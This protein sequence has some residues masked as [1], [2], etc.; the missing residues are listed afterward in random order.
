MTLASRG[1]VEITNLENNIGNLPVKLGTAKLKEY[2][3]NLIHYY[4]LKLLENEIRNLDNKSEKIRNI[5]SQNS[6]YANESFNHFKIIDLVKSNAYAKLSEF[7]PQSR[8]KRGLLNGVGTIFKSITG[9]LDANDGERYDNLIKQLHD[10]QIKITNNMKIQNSLSIKLIDEYKNYIRKINTNEK[11]L[12][13]KINNVINLINK[14][15]LDII[16]LKDTLARFINVYEVILSILQDIENSVSFAKLGIIHP[17]IIKPNDLLNELA[18]LTKTYNPNQ[19]PIEITSDNLDSIMKLLNLECFIYKGKIT[20]II[21]IPI[22]LEESFELFHLYPVPIPTAV[23]GQFAVILPRSKFIAKNR[24]DFSFLNEPCITLRQ[25]QYFCKPEMIESR[26]VHSNPCEIGII[27]KGNT[28][29]CKPVLLHPRSL[30]IERLEN[31]NQ[32]IFVIQHLQNVRFT[33]QEQDEVKVLKGTYLIEIPIGCQVISGTKKVTNR[34]FVKSTS[35]PVLFPR[36]DSHFG[37]N[38]QKT[39][40]EIENIGLEDLSDLKL[41]FEASVPQ[42]N[43]IIDYNPSVLSLVI[44]GLLVLGLLMFVFQRL[45]TKPTRGQQP[46][47][48]ELSDVQLP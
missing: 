20:Y 11:L 39:P 27:D 42:V 28:S 30:L 1:K 35:Q 16:I 13:D 21:N 22:S 17:S 10:N 3:H 40:V 4:D 18:L 9:N 44:T 14:S 36:I 24:L 29:T 15:D 26:Q 43:D 32:W 2:S 46:E 31:T 38:F 23:E 5:I 6:Y 19:F 8:Q 45:R 34:D 41:K 47:G 48:F 25:Q 7:I 12:E 37:E 33:C